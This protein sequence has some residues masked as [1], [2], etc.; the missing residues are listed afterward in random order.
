MTNPQIHPI[1]L[2]FIGW[3]FYLS[4]KKKITAYTITGECLGL[5]FWLSVH[6]VIKWLVV[7]CFDGNIEV[8]SFG[9]YFRFMVMFMM[10]RLVEWGKAR[11][12]DSEK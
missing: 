10:G 12:D 3:Y 6:P 5:L 9:V 4:S 8:M 7:K 1:A 11:T 2:I